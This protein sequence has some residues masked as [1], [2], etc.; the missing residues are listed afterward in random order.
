MKPSAFYLLCTILL[1]SAVIHA[2]NTE[3]SGEKLGRGRE[4]KRRGAEH[5]A[6]NPNADGSGAKADGVSD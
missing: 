2:G 3:K 1:I 5:L 6:E 4:G